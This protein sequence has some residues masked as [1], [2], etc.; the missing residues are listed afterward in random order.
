ML[1]VAQSFHLL[2]P[3]GASLRPLVFVAAESDAMSETKLGQVRSL[4]QVGWAKPRKGL[5]NGSGTAAGVAARGGNS[6]PGGDD[7]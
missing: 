5:S 1:R 7:G 4:K 6:A 3:V 2:G